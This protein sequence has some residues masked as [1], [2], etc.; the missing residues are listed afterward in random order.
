MMAALFIALMVFAMILIDLGSA[1]PQGPTQPLDGRHQA[2]SITVR[3]FIVTTV[4]S[5]TYFH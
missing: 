4:T 2:P 5:G 1:P 3:W